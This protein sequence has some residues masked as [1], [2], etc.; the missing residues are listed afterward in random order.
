[1]LAAERLVT[2]GRYNRAA[3]ILHWL[4]A[5]LIL[6]NVALGLF[7]TELRGTA[8][9]R[10]AHKA[11][12]AI[13]V[14]IGVAVLVLALVRVGW[15]L[16]HQVPAFPPMRRQLAWLAR[17]SHVSLYVAMVIV[18]A[19]GVVI[20]ATSFGLVPLPLFPHL[21]L[22]TA[23]TQQFAGLRS[24]GPELRQAVA[25]TIQVHKWLAL[26]MCGLLVLHIGAALAHHFWFA[27]DVLLRML[28]R[29]GPAS[30]AGQHGR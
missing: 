4:M 14:L 22:S 26:S 24:A 27:D 21:H 8:S 12:L 11:A 19:A 6:I 2:P 25:L 17:L 13:H 3:V 29:R 30:A 10:P 16:T 9:I 7:F 1:V 20:L 28:L 15:R 18:P 23:A 5:G